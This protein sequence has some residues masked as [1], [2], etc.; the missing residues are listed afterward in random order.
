MLGGIHAGKRSFGHVDMT[1]VPMGTWSSDHM[2]K[3]SGYFH[4]IQYAVDD[5]VHRDILRFCFVGETN[6]VA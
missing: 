4:G 3:C 2:R 1:T 5:L 6:A